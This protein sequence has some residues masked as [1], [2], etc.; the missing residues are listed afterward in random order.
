MVVKTKKYD[1]GLE[2]TD[3]YIVQLTDSKYNFRNIKTVGQF[4][5][6]LEQILE[7]MKELSNDIKIGEIHGDKLTLS[8]VYSGET[9]IFLDGD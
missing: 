1:C 6:A 8:I 9:G 5:N 4:K 3:G 2:R 7:D